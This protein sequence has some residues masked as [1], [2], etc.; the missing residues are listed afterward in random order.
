MDL[1]SNTTVKMTNDNNE[2][3]TA[4]S[5]EIPETT[6]MKLCPRNRPNPMMGFKS[7]LSFFFLPQTNEDAHSS[8]DSEIRIN[9]IEEELKRQRYLEGG[10][11]TRKFETSRF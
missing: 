10:D 1:F 5:I 9:S 3:A 6:R 11:Q 8:K 7:H 4:T 2:Y